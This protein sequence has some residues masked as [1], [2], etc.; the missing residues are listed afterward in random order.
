MNPVAHG[1]NQSNVY[2][3]FPVGYVLLRLPPR[4]WCIQMVSDPG[5]LRLDMGHSLAHSL[6]QLPE[7]L[8]REEQERHPEKKFHLQLVPLLRPL[9]MEPQEMNLSV[10]R[11]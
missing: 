8:S 3:A 10:R 11:R 9:R 4:R 2:I 1:F 5:L 7:N 6:V